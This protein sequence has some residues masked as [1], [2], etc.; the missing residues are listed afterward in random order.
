MNK[1]LQSAE[2]TN[3]NEISPSPPPPPP[4]IQNVMKTVDADSPPRQKHIPFWSENPN[5]LFHQKYMFEFFPVEN[6]TYEQKLNAVSRTV[7]VLTVV[8]FLLTRNFSTLLVGVI[9][10]GAVFLLH[11][12]RKKEEE[13]KDS[14]KFVENAKEGF[15]NPAEVYLRENNLPMNEEIFAPPT[16]QNPFSNVLMTDYEYNPNKKPALPAFNP[17]I[18]DRIIDKTKQMVR[19]INSDQP[20]ITDKLFKDLGDNLVFEQSMR[21]FVSNPATTIPNDSGTFAQFCYGSMVSNKE[22]NVFAAAKNLPRHNLY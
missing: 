22:G 9:T 11:F 6:M 1:P 2:T 16:A 7:V 18:N 3:E 10:L 8:G 21:Q 19:D 13:K 14:K 17:Q 4:D 12:Y 5:I 15:E 20:G